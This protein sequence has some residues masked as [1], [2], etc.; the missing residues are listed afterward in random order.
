MPTA[1]PHFGSLELALVLAGSNGLVRPLAE[2][3]LALDTVQNPVRNP[4]WNPVR[5]PVRN[6]LV[7]TSLGN[8]GLSLYQV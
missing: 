5:N 8:P 2:S 1:T 7:R 6:R 3:V 4:V